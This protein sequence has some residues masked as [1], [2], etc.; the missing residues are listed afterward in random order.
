M[1]E[2]YPTTQSESL[3]QAVTHEW[4]LKLNHASLPHLI[5]IAAREASQGSKHYL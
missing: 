1:I 2:M 4:N 5:D 3:M